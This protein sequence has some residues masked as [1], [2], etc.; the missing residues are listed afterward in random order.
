[1]TQEPAEKLTCY[2]HPDRETLL[3]CNQCGRPICPECAVKVP[4]GYRCRECIHE[5][6]KRFDTAESKDYIIGGVIAFVIS[7][8]GSVLITMIPYV[9]VWISALLFGG[10]I[11]HLVCELVR[12]AVQKRR[13]RNLTL[14]VIIAAGAGALLPRLQEILLSLQFIGASP[15]WLMNG[16]LQI[17]MHILFIIV[18][19]GTIWA[20]MNGMVFRS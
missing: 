18:L 15:V 9:P 4:T 14:T 16:L 19:C 13:S 2:K 20:E 5:Q 7:L 1:M 6:Q 3:R 10:L 17:F 12:R 8:I 11:G